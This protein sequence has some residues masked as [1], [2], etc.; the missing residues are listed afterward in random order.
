LAWP[1][2]KAQWYDLWTSVQWKDV[3]GNWHTVQGWQGG[4]DTITFDGGV[5]GEKY[6]W[7]TP[8]YMGCGP[9]RW[10]VYDSR[11]ADGQFVVSDEFYLPR[12][13]YQVVELKV[14]LKY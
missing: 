8:N 7:V 4:L 12:Y 14:D 11:Y 10:I 13:D 6:W 5:V 1:W 2:D 9:F 3:Q